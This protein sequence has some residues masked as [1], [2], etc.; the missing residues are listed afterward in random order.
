[1]RKQLKMGITLSQRDVSME[2]D[3][4]KP[5]TREQIDMDAYNAKFAAVDKWL[6]GDRKDNL[7]YG[8]FLLDPT[9][10]S[11]LHFKMDNKPVKLY[12][13]QD[14]I[15]NDQYRY[16]YFEGANQIGKSVTF[17]NKGANNLL[18]D[19]GHT[20]NEGIISASLDLAKF[21]M[22]R[23]KN[24][25]NRME[26]ID[27]TEAVGDANNV[28]MLSV[29]VKDYDKP[30]GK[31]VK[32]SNLL[33]C[34]PCTVGSLG[35]DFHDLNLD[36]FEFWKDVDLQWYYNQVAKP[37]TFTTRGNHFIMSNPNGMDNYGYDLTQQKLPNGQKKWHV[38]NFNYLDR[39][40][41]TE[42]FLE[43]E[44]VGSTRQQIESTLLAIR[45]LSD[46]NYFTRE[47]IERS[48]DPK[49]REIDMVGKQPFAFLD[50]GAKHDQS[51]FAMGYTTP[52]ADNPKIKHLHVP[53]MKAY[54]V[55]YPLTRV[56]GADSPESD[57]WHY[58]KSVK[59]I[60]LEWGTEGINPVF[61]VDATGDNSIVP[62][63]NTQGVYPIAVKMSGPAKSGMYQRF[64]FFME[65]G[66]LHRVKD[67]E[68]DYQCAHLIMQKSPSGYLKI[69]HDSEEDLDDAPDTFAGLI[70]LADSPD[71]VTPSLTII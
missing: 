21:Q 45:T 41:N 14:I 46:R 17:V 60:L 37:R 19:H 26:D 62:L 3:Y 29:D 10:F 12:P 59:E 7:A 28:F 69:H 48:Y 64:K 5:I 61:G 1:M 39:P 51:Y 38:Y 33:L 32:Y 52:H 16:K 15:L 42:A 47:E 58:E 70:Y 2:I 68:F 30:L 36:E 40:G 13:F 8:R 57:G 50:V 66:L 44:K 25:L 24:I 67:K 6:A 63:F 18:I 11:Y 53:I 49:L 43:E 56:V 55:G 27:F 35:Y 31:Q 34:A 54:P 23:V 71:I 65:N 22:R 4:N 9:T 20:H